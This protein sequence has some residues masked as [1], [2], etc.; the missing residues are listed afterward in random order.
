MCNFLYALVRLR[1][2]SQLGA[3]R[4]LQPDSIFA[5]VPQLSLDHVIIEFAEFLQHLDRVEVNTCGFRGFLGPSEGHA[6]IFVLTRGIAHGAEVLEEYLRRDIVCASLSDICNDHGNTT[7]EREGTRGHALLAAVT[8]LRVFS[9][10]AVT[11][12]GRLGRTLGACFLATRGA[13][14]TSG[15]RRCFSI[16]YVFARSL[17]EAICGTR[18]PFRQSRTAS[19]VVEHKAATWALVSPCSVMLRSRYS[20]ASVP[21]AAL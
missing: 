14:H 21:I 17:T 3:N 15:R 20:L 11:A 6:S 4:H 19:E 7:F 16:A 8:R 5:S 2:H 13:S 12:T 18:A 9:T 10:L 1:K